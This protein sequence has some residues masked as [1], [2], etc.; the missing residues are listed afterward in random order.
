MFLNIRLP[1]DIS[2]GA[3]GGPKFSTN[4]ITLNNGNEQRNINWKYP[5]HSYKISYD[6][7]NRTMIK[8]LISF[9][10]ITKGAAHS[11]LFKDWL[12]FE[13]ENQSVNQLPIKTSSDLDT[14]T[15]QLSKL[16]KIHDLSY[17]RKISKPVLGSLKIFDDNS[18]LLEENKD[19]KCD[20]TKGIIEFYQDISDNYKANF[21][22]NLHV[23]FDQDECEFTFDAVELYSWKSIKIIELTD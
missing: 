20:Y 7:L 6:V 5:K 11:F 1:D 2:Y 17:V 23:R 9:F 3:V 14:K 8:D 16:Y 21:E 19:Y 12:D 22:F 18:N 4:I 10:F 15:F 13:A